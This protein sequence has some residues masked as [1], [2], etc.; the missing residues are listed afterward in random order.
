MT[1]FDGLVTVNAGDPP[2]EF[3]VS[4]FR[5][6]AIGPVRSAV[7]LVAYEGDRSAGGDKGS[8]NGTQS[9]DNLFDSS[10]RRFGQP[11]TSKTPD[12][13]NQLGFDADVLDTTG[14]LGNGVTSAAVKLE[15]TGD[16]YL[17]GVGWM[18]TDLFAPDVQSSKS[19]ADLNGGLVEPGDELEYVIAGANRGQDAALNAVVTDPVPAN[20]SFVPGSLR[21]TGGTGA[22]PRSDAAGDDAAEFDGGA[23]QVVFRVGAGAGTLAGGRIAPN[24]TLR[25]AL[26]GARGG[27]VAVRHRDHEPGARE[28][29]RGDPRRPGRADHERHAPDDHGARPGDE[30]ELRDRRAG[31][32]WAHGH[33]RR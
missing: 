4:G 18:A 22:G 3:S 23:G 25:G 17:P 9:Q 7:G 2:H 14:V 21:V 12:Y 13:D 11:V 19:V 20:T 29:P 33:E 30:Q 1:V 8:L 6:P 24:E 26:P 32:L 28:L 16:S 5:T 10:I 15:T 27:W 31:H